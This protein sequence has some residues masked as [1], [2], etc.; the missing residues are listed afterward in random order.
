MVGSVS[1]HGFSETDAEQVKGNKAV[2][3][4]AYLLKSRYVS[5]I[6]FITVLAA[7]SLF[8]IK[9]L[10]EIDTSQ[11]GSLSA[12]GLLLPFALVLVAYINRFFFWTILT[13]SYQLKASTPMAA[14]AFFYSILGRYIPGKAGLFLLRLRAYSGSSRKKVGAA[15]ITE[16][17]STLLAASLLVIAGALFIPVE[18]QLLTRWLPA[19]AA[20]LFLLMLHPAVL[21][22]SINLLFKLL[23]R[24][25]LESFPS[26]G[27]VFSITC[28]YMCTG[29]LHGMALFLIINMFSPLE[30]STYPVVTGAY[31]MA[32]LAGI[33][34]FF[35]PG[36]LGVREGVLFILL[37]VITSAEYV[38]L[39][40]ALMRILTLAAEVSLALVSA[41]LVRFSQ[42]IQY[43]SSRKTPG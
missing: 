33:F 2:R 1:V 31:Y 36:G 30:F 41:A 22:K 6:L 32:G 27:T 39:S 5:A 35:A 12:T 40:A 38:I 20:V 43:L 14:K 17:I 25:P 10:S 28:G 26:F 11:I 9:T 4:I 21:R 23:R 3:T 37:P 13:K 42:R 8:A 18:N 29:L 34:A 24:E 15:L 16:Y 19:A 7:I